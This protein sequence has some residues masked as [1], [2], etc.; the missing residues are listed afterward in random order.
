MHEVGNVIFVGS[1]GFDST[2]TLQEADFPLS[3][4]TVMFVEPSFFP[5]TT[6]DEDTVAMSVSA[7]FHVTEFVAFD[8]DI[9]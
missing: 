8:G 7:D 4:V 3:V 2:Y 1:I 5:V 6:P 9:L